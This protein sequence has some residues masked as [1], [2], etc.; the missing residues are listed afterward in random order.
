[1]FDGGSPK[2]LIFDERFEDFVERSN[3]FVD[4]N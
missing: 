4:G 3:L 2:F 1:M